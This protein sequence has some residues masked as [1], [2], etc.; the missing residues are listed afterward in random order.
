MLSAQ[1]DEL[2]TRVGP[3]NRMGELLRRYW[4]PALVSE[5]STPGGEP[6][7]VR[8]LGEDLVAFRGT[9]GRVGLIQENCPHRGASLYFGRDENGPGGTCGL[10]CA[11]HGR[12]LEADGTCIDMPSEP[13]SSTFKDRATAKAYPTHESGGI[14]WTGPCTPSCR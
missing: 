5:V 2:L 3:G 7:R 10:R 8:L 14:V 1:D 13:P 4:T 12:Q 11:Y 9:N 6:V